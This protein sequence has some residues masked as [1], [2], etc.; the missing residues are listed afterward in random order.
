MN[1]LISAASKFSLGVKSEPKSFEVRPSPSDYRVK[2]DL[3]KPRTPAI[4][5]HER[6]AAPK[7]GKEEFPCECV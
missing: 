5:M 2:L 6:L 1:A 4:G 3:V 7:T